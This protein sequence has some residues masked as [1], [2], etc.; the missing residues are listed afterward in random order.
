MSLSGRKGVAIVGDTG[1]IHSG[2][3]GLLDAVEH[4][5]DV[6]VIILYNKYSAMTPGAQPIPGLERV[7][8]LVEACGVD[9]IDEVQMESI[10][11][12]ELRG[13]SNGVLLS[14][15]CRCCS[16]MLDRGSCT[17]ESWAVTLLTCWGLL[18]YSEAP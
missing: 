9:T 17:N 16:L 6:L 4:G 15:G 10:T 18:C 1:V 11:K 5:H 7:R 12:D 13:L 3:T 2:I 14:V 8:A